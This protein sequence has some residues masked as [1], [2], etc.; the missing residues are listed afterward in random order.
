[1]AEGPKEDVEFIEPLVV[2]GVPEEQGVSDVRGVPEVPIRR[3]RHGDDAPDDDAANDMLTAETAT[4][5]APTG[6]AGDDGGTAAVVLGAAAGTIAGA[7]L[8]PVGAIVGAIAGGALA[9][10]VT[11]TADGDGADI[12][13]LDQPDRR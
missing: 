5:G 3:V 2:R 11:D 1:M 7:F 8:G 10:S 6:E 4:L 12:T 13:D 9:S